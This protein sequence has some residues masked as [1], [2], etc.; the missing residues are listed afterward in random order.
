V[1]AL[2]RNRR[3]SRRRW[4]N[5]DPFAWLRSDVLLAAACV[6][7]PA[8]LQVFL[9]MNANW[10][11][12]APNA[13]AGGAVLTYRATRALAGRGG[14]T[15]AKALRALRAA[16]WVEVVRE[17]TRPLGPGGARGEAAVY[18][19]PRRHGGTQPPVELPP[20]LPRPHGTIRWNVHRLRHDVGKLSGAALKVLAFAVAHRHRSR[21]SEV[22]DPSP[23]RLPARQMARLLGLS[24][25][26]VARAIE[27]L[28]ETRCLAAVER[29]RGRAPAVPPAVCG[30][31]S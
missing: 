12:T 10:R 1:S 31:P 11:P 14:T 26:T 25:A 5:A 29:A 30:T 7:K 19:I 15:I 17:G 22:V 27:E 8:E 3:R 24:P 2:Q 20:N 16:G 23:F 4:A 13:S 28:L 6:L 18:D 9:L 21:E